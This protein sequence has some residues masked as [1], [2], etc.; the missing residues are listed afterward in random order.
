MF[1]RLAEMSFAEKLAG[2]ERLNRAG[3]QFLLMGLQRD[4]PNESDAQIRLRF[5]IALLGET[6]AMKAY[7]QDVE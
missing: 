7:G 4:Y 6:L 2:V 1:E 5:A 3:R